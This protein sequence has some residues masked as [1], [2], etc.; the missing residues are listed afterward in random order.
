[1]ELNVLFSGKSICRAYNDIFLTLINR[2]D[3]N[4]SIM[5]G[6]SPIFDHTTFAELQWRRDSFLTHIYVLSPGF[7]RRLDLLNEEFV[8]VL[9]DLHGLQSIRDCPNFDCYDATDMIRV[10]NHQASIQSRL[11]AL[12]ATKVSLLSECCHLAAYIFACQLCCKVWR[13]SSIPV[14]K[15]HHYELGL[16]LSNSS[17]FCSKSNIF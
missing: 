6:S 7:E 3:L 1:M 13:A 5:T 11:A 9:E 16:S 17:R 15:S 12:S 2:Q 8:E 4:C 14:R 10:D